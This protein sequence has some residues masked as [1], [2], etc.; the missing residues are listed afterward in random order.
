MRSSPSPA[1]VISIIALFV[2]LGG[3]GYAAVQINGKNIKRGTVTSKQVKDRSLTGTDVKDGSVKRADLA[4]D[5]FASGPKGDKGEAGAQGTSSLNTDVPS[6]TTVSGAW[7]VAADNPSP[8]VVRTSR[9]VV[10]LPARAS[11]NLLGEDVNFKDTGSAGSGDDDSSCTGTHSNPTAPAGKVCIY[12]DSATSLNG[13]V[14][15]V[16]GVSAG[17]LRTAFQIRIV[18]PIGMSYDAFGKWAYTAP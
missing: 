13:T 14:T 15:T 17:A 1:L 2:A 7:A 10:N 11:A 4:A 9:F 8:N 6:G 18:L 12:L 5:A 16:E 3:T